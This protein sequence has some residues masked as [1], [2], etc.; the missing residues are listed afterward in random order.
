MK[1]PIKIK[2]GN[3]NKLYLLTFALLFFPFFNLIAQPS[4]DAGITTINNPLSLA[5]PNTYIVQV[6]LKNFGSYN[7]SSVNI[8]WA[9]N[10]IGQTPYVWS[11]NMAQNASQASIPIGPYTFTYGQNTIK[12]WT[13]LPNGVPDANLTN[14]TMTLVIDICQP[15]AG[16]YTIGGLTANFA[17][18]TEAMNVLGTCGISGN[19][20]LDVAP[21]TYTEQFTI[22]A[23]SGAGSSSKVTINGNNA[24]ITFTPSIND[25]R[26]VILLDSA[27]YVTIDHLNITVPNNATYGWNILLTN[28]CHNI[29]IKN[30]TIN[31]HSTS[32]TSNY[33][34]IVASGS[35]TSMFTEGNNIKNL[36]LTN[37]IITGG[38]IGA[39]L[40]GENANKMDSLVFQNNTFSNN[41]LYGVYIL[42][43]N[44]PS[45]IQNTIDIRNTGAISNLGS[46]I[47]F[48]NTSGAIT[49]IK[50]KITNAGQY[51][52]YLKNCDPTPLRSKIINNM[53]GGGFRN[54]NA[55]GIY[56]ESSQKLDIFFNSINVNTSLSRGINVLANTSSLDIRNNSFAYTGSGSGFCAYYAST[57]SLI[58][59][60]NNSYF[61]NGSLFVVYGD[62][63]PTISALRAKNIPAGNDIHSRVGNPYYISPT[64][65]HS[66]GIQFFQRGISISG[67]TDDIDGQTRPS[68]PCIG[69]DEYVPPLNDL[70]VVE[71]VSPK[72]SCALSTAETIVVKIVNF[73]GNAQSNFPIAASIDAGVTFIGPEI[74]TSNINPGDT[75][76]YTFTHHVNLSVPKT[77]YSGAVVLLPNDQNHANDTII[78]IIE[79]VPFI[80]NYPYKEIFDWYSGWVPVAQQGPNQWIQGR[81]NKS[82][83]NSDHSGMNMEAFVTKISA[84]YDNNVID[85]LVSPCFDLSSLVQPIFSVWLNFKTEPNYDA[86]ILESSVDGGTTWMKVVGDLGFYNNNSSLGP[87]APPKWS[88]SNGSWTK[89]KTSILSLAGESD[90]RFRF[91]FRSNSAVNDEGIAIDEVMV[92]DPPANDVGIVAVL[93]PDSAICGVNNDSL[94]VVVKNF[95]INAQNNIPLNVII[96]SPDSTYTLSHVYVGNLP[97]NHSDT[98]FIGLINTTTNGIYTVKAYTSLATDTI[99]NDNDTVSYTFVIAVPLTI[100]YY[101]DFESALAGWQ[102]NMAKGYAHGSASSVLYKNL[103]SSVHSCFARSP[104]I[105]QVG[106]SSILF[107]DYRFVDYAIIPPYTATVLGAGD[108]LKVLVSDDCGATFTQIDAVNSSNHTASANMQTRNIPLTAYNGKDILIKFEATRALSGNYFIDLDNILISGIPEVDLGHDTAICEGETL[109]LDAKN[110]TSNTIYSWFTTESPTIFATTQTINVSSPASYIVIVNDGF[111]NTGT[112]TI[113]ITNN[114]KPV[115]SL[116]NNFSICNGISDTLKIGTVYTPF[117]FEKLRGILPENWTIVDGGLLNIIQTSEGGYLLLDSEN[118]T[119]TTSA[120]DLSGHSNVKLS[121]DIAGYGSGQNNNIHIMVS[122]DN[123]A[124]WTQQFTT[125]TTTSNT[126]YISG[127]V[128]NVSSNSAQVIFKIFRPVTSGKGVRIRNFNLSTKENSFSV[129]WSDASHNDSLVIN[130]AG[131]Y[132][133]T[134]TNSQG[135]S[136]TDSLIVSYFPE[137]NV[138][139]GTDNVIICTGESTI[140]NAG[141]N[142]SSYK[143]QNN[144]NNQTFTAVSAGDYWVE[145]VNSYGCHSSDTVTVQVNPAPTVSLPHDTAICE[146]TSV[147]I[148]AGFN[149]GY[150]YNWKKIPSPIT[151]ST[152]HTLNI[153]AAGSY[154]VTVDNG[155]LTKAKDTINVTVNT[156]QQVS[157]GNDTIICANNNIIIHAGNGFS[158]YLWFDNSTGNSLVLDSTGF[159]LSTAQIYVLA[160]DIHGCVSSD[161][162][163]VTFDPCTG[164]EAIKSQ[165]D[166]RIYPNPA[167]DLITIELSNTTQPIEISIYTVEGLL[168]HHEKNS[169]LSGLNFKKSINLVPYNKG[170]YFINIFDGINTSIK[171]LVIY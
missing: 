90:V 171:K 137:V 126:N 47:S 102:H 76:T 101:E 26:Y 120:Y 8:N 25:K 42:Y 103:N 143:W 12:S 60:D 6:T 71:W 38:Y 168:I 20:I 163:L 3:F 34:G 138:D 19:I 63:V 65:L 109:V 156:P 72:T 91:Q 164:N 70:A 127:G 113:T 5:A 50:N 146:N 100:P 13:S 77:Y 153:T 135:C 115:F 169:D 14:D 93:K 54:V 58:A 95:G 150:T 151:L 48:E 83:I 86:M 84:N 81:P 87:L 80:T 96:H 16:T 33:A 160:T 125:N 117:Y 23:I 30:C 136:S 166:L 131:I 106:A 45:F 97:Y 21:G 46:G 85:N 61:N 11:G 104:K 31:T 1:L 18:F 78:N 107:Y 152:T 24:T 98:I 68:V 7:L 27:Q 165:N 128:F 69:A 158:S 35:S 99:V 82:V 148:D 51:G 170:V 129:V 119:I 67:I 88:G 116:G 44:A 52:L 114:L 133:A 161:T 124:T 134:V 74:V 141:P 66:N 139:L 140:L 110:H 9:V 57:A 55:N 4:N 37:N 144:S 10:G 121:I 32:A 62:T 75:L 145:V 73:G 28:A 112:D 49:F 132:W 39:R 17:S 59:H 92:Y 40:N 53:I 118:D 147:I 149:A 79:S 159:G 56:I 36:Q 89:Y 155:C 43:G 111:G 105:G 122:E 64:D 2:S 15:L 167:H 154:T 41:Y 130:T 94:M 162:I 142:F 108:T 29:I 123:G 22:P 157:I